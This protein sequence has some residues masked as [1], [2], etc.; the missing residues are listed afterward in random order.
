MRGCHGDALGNQSADP[1]GQSGF[2][3]A[4][5]GLDAAEAGRLFRRNATGHRALWQVV[6]PIRLRSA[7]TLRSFSEAEGPRR[8]ARRLCAVFLAQDGRRCRPDAS[9]VRRTREHRIP[10]QRRAASLAIHIGVPRNGRLAAARTESLHSAGSRFCERGR[11]HSPLRSG[12]PRHCLVRRLQPD[13]SAATGHRDLLA[14]PHLSRVSG[15]RRAVRRAVVR[16]PRCGPDRGSN[17]S[18]SPGGERTTGRG[19]QGFGG[20]CS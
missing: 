13:V 12:D 1:A 17:S 19:Y 7:D 3:A 9:G 15:S 18:R 16:P 5:G 10:A 11:Q 6:S 2:R 4:M 14:V 8:C 20:R